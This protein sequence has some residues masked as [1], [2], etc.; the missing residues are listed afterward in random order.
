MNNEVISRKN[1]EFWNEMCGSKLPDFPGITY[2]RAESLKGFCDW[3]FIF[4]PYFL[5][6]YRSIV[7]KVKMF[8]DRSGVRNR[9]AETGGVRHSLP[10]IGRRG[11]AGC[12][13]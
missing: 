2:D 1:M 10:R 3:Y 9:I 8:S 7:S 11:R 13:G 6:L 5:N 12:N 4:Y